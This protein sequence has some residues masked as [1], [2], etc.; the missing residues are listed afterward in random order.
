MKRIHLLAFA[1][2]AASSSAFA[3]D[4][5]YYPNGFVSSAIR[6]AQAARTAAPSRAAGD[7][8]TATAHVQKSRAQV[9]AETREAARL[10]LLNTSEAGAVQ[11]TPEQAH[12]IE[13]AGL[14]AVGIETLSK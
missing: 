4:V 3:D 5:D 13:L 10:G 8:N 11:P 12:Q 1:A 6:E 9:V 7:A 2:L 14:R